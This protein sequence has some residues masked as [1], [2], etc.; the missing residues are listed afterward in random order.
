MLETIEPVSYTTNIGN[1]PQRSCIDRTGKWAFGVH[2]LNNVFSG[3]SNSAGDQERSSEKRE[4]RE[5]SSGQE[6]LQGWG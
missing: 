5:G 6:K 4:L 2:H 1:L 3:R